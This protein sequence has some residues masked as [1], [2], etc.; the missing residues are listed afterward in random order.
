MPKPDEPKKETTRITLPSR[1]PGAASSENHDT[2]QINLPGGAEPAGEPPPPVT[3]P[4]MARGPLPP[5][6]AQSLTPQRRIVPPPPM[7]ALAA[8][9]SIMPPPLPRPPASGAS[10]VPPPPLAQPK[11]E[12]SRINVVPDQPR[13]E[14]SRI[15]ISS[16]KPKEETSRIN[17]VPEPPKTVRM[18]K[19][20]PL[21]TVTATPVTPPPAPVTFAPAE[22]VPSIISSIPIGLCW[23]LVVIS[24]AILLIEIWT[25]IT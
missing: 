25:Y 19:T 2:T 1:Q 7:P 11:K 23:A 6:P 20:Q 24:A 4:P 21:V 17:I 22:P 14:T 5:P 8:K 10:V 3:G 12:T 15:N 9:P 18:S 13:K 16:G